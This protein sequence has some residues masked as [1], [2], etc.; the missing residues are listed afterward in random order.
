MTV[1]CHWAFAAGRFVA[2]TDIQRRFRDVFAGVENG[3]VAL[4]FCFVAIGATKHCRP[5]QQTPAAPEWF[6]GE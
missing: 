4:E 3:F 1:P 6:R 2:L 5:I